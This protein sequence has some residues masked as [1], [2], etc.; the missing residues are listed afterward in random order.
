[1]KRLEEQKMPAGSG[2]ATPCL[3]HHEKS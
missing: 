2:L 1:M 3:D